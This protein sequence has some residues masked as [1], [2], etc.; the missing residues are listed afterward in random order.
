MKRMSYVLLCFILTSKI[1]SAAFLSMTLVSF[2]WTSLF[3]TGTELTAIAENNLA[4]ADKI[5]IDEE[6]SN[7]SEDQILTEA[8]AITEQEIIALIETKKQ[9]LLAEDET[10]TQNVTRKLYYQISLKSRAAEIR[11][12]REN[13]IGTTE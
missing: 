6:L 9:A 5:Q 11:K 12:A 3:V 2:G 10:L 4:E 8:D 1:A 7:K 13:D